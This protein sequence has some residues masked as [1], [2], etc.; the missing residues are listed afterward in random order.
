M[1][2]IKYLNIKPKLY[3]C[4]RHPK[5]TYEARVLIYVII[6]GKICNFL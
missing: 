5:V 1:Y 6:V 2:F 4:M 3:A